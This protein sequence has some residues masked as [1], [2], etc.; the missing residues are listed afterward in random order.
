MKIFMLINLKLLT[1][2][3]SFL[4]NITEHELFSANILAYLNL[5]EEKISSTA[6]L[7]MKKSFITWFERHFNK[8]NNPVFKMT[9]TYCLH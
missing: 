5:L 7:S 4:L 8:K 9:R 2:A 3:K 6:K 1:I